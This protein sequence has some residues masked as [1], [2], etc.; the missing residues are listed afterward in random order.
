MYELQ[1][2][3]MTCAGCAGRVTRAVRGVDGAA[4]VHVDL[5]GKT[6]Q[7]QTSAPLDVVRSAIVG[8]GYPVTSEDL[9]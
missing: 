4:K 8:A 7:V 3:G 1:V 2:D 5:K 6:V 9:D